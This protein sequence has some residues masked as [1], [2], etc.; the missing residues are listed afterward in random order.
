MKRIKYPFMLFPLIILMAA[1]GGGSSDESVVTPMPAVTEGPIED[2][3]Y[4]TGD[5]DDPYIMVTTE[6]TLSEKQ[7]ELYEKY[8]ENLDISIF[9]NVDP[10]D[11]AHVW[12]ECGIMGKWEC[13]YNLYSQAGLYVTKEEWQK[14]NYEDM[15]KLD[16][17]SRRS[18]ANIMFPFLQEGSFV[19]TGPGIGRL[20]FESP[21]MGMEGQYASGAV[22]DN[23]M[24]FVKENGIWMVKFHPFDPFED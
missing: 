12:I 16:I 9:E 21:M 10:V 4:P 7:I 13:E 2:L 18:M 15:E 22:Q 19:E 14:M 17:R 20:E 23:E 5:F 3:P 1:C 8:T 24:W 11:T 6:F